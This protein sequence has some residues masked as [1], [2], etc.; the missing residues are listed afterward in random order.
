MPTPLPQS[1][2][3]SGAEAKPAAG[4]AAVARTVVITPP[5]LMTV[6]NPVAGN[7]G[8]TTSGPALIQLLPLT[9]PETIIGSAA[10]CHIVVAHPSV[11]PQQA[12]LTLTGNRYVLDD[13][14]NGQTQVSFSGEPTQLR[15]VQRNALRDGSLIQVGEVQLRFRQSAA[16][17]P[18]LE[19]RHALA[20]AGVT[21]GSDP[22]CELLISG[23]APRQA[24][25]WQDGQRW[26]V[27]E[28]AGSGAFISYQGDP[29]QER[30]VAGRNALKTGST[31]RIATTTLRLEV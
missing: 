2:F 29:A 25:V 15:A 5:P 22:T 14:S 18:L 24:R 27:E 4:P 28:L 30:P 26:V 3:P 13:L 7:P 20:S 19:R 6:A 1:A 23:A 17:P 16:Q 9:T 21:L 31:L 8:L 12:R 11:K 10:G